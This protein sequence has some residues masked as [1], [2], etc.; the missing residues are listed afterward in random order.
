[1][2]RKENANGRDVHELLMEVFEL[3]KSMSEFSDIVHEQT[4]LSTA[5]RKIFR[6]IV[7]NDRDVTVPDIA[8]LLGI[9]RQFVQKSCNELEH[10]GDII[11]AENPRHKR[12]RYVVITEKGKIHWKDLC[13]REHGFIDRLLPDIERTKVIEATELLKRIR[14]ES[15]ELMQTV[16]KD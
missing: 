7:T 16:L 6:A 11:F 12:S 3:Q 5:K 13:D 14:I 1:M 4:G 15:A 9:S 2:D 10:S 8:A